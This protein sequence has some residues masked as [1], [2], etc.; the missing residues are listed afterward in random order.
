MDVL[1]FDI[2]PNQNMADLLGFRFVEFNQLLQHSDIVSLHAPLNEKTFHIID[3]SA[4]KLFKRGALLI[5]TARG[6]LVDTT[7]LLKALDTKQLSGAGLDVLEGE[8]NLSEEAMIGADPSVSRDQLQSALRNLSLM[9]RQDLVV[10]PHIAF[11][12]KEAIQRILDTT[13]ENIRAFRRGHAI[14]TV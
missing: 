8:S 7:A 3:E 1:A 11:D 14:N 9:R 5:N 13:I 6:E 2:N 10:T 12:S 4:F